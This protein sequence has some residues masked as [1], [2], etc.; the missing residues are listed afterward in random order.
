MS[1]C[2]TCL[3]L[4]SE[5]TFNFLQIDNDMIFENTP[6]STRKLCKFLLKTSKVNRK[7][8]IKGLSFLSRDH[9]FTFGLLFKFAGDDTIP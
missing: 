9:A 5:V 4:L 8:G 3:S 1:N 7:G 6:E 2:I